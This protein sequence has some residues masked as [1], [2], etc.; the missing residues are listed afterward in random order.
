[1]KKTSSQRKLRKL[2]RKL[3][4]QNNQTK[5]RRRCIPLV[6]LTI[7]L[8]GLFF[9][10]TPKQPPETTFGYERHFEHGKIPAYDGDPFIE[11]S[12]KPF[13]PQDGI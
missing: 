2:S 5:T 8:T 11:L 7:L 12:Q 10:H 9:I 1:M 13:Y 6:L 3:L 4:R